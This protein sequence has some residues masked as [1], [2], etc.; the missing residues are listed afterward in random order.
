MTTVFCGMQRMII[1][2]FFILSFSAAFFQIP[3]AMA[4]TTKVIEAQVKL[5]I[6]GDGIIE[7]AEEC[8]GLDL[9]GAT[10][11]SIGYLEGDLSCHSSCDFETTECIPLPSPT[12]TPTP[13]PTS[14][15]ENSSTS[16]DTSSSQS[17][18]STPS[19]VESITQQLQEATQQVQQY[20]STAS[21]NLRTIPPKIALYL[22]ESAELSSEELKETIE[23]F[24]ATWRQSL[25]QP[26]FNTNPDCDF[27]E[28]TVCDIVDFSVLLYYIESTDS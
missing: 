16:N 2:L 6:C 22:K 23:K 18:S 17:T 7:G 24:A 8:E 28:D 25:T 15:P 13:E 3:S 10:C 26:S 5:S 21:Q 12:P 9:N 19:V 1:A 11:A 27:N 14:S 20:L 4:Q